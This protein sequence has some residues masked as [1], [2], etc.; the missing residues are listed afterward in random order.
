MGKGAFL[1]TAG[2]A[3]VLGLAFLAFGLVLAEASIR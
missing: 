2:I 3:A 1:R